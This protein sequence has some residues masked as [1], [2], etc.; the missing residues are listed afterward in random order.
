MFSAVTA[1]VALL[2]SLSGSPAAASAT[3]L[4]GR[5]ETVSVATEERPGLTT[6]NFFCVFFRM[7]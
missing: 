7:C 4:D 6:H 1:T 2:V 5:T 3:A